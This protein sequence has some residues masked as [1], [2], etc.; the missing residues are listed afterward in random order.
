MLFLVEVDQ[1]KSG[2][3]LTADAGRAFVEQ[4]IFPTLARA[5][6]LAAEKRILAGG[7]AVGRISLRFIL[8]ADSLPEVDRLVSSLPLW[9]L[10]ETRITPLVPFADRRKS[11]QALLDQ[12]AG[13]AKPL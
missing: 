5:D 4:I 1:V 11:V 3:P 9:P 13:A 7:A 6:Q 2:M 12:L 10:A 8:E